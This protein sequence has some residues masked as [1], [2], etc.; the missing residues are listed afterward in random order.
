MIAATITDYVDHGKRVELE[1]VT[2]KHEV[3]LIKFGTL[4]F[5]VMLV[6]EG[7]KLI[8]RRVEIADSKRQVTVLP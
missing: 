1:C 5:A 8:G 3:V 4:A 6:R 2:D 7:G